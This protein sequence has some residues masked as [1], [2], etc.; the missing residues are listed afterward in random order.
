MIHY[1]NQWQHLPVNVSTWQCHSRSAFEHPVYA[2]AKDII[3]KQC[4][5]ILDVGCGIAHDA[6]LFPRL[7]YVGLDVTPKFIHE[8]HRRGYS[9]LV[10]SCLSL[11]F[12]DHAFDAVLTNSLLVHLPPAMWRPSLREMVR[13]ASKLV[14]TIEG[15]WK[16]K[17]QYR[18]AEQYPF[19]GGTLMFYN[20]AYGEAEVRAFMCDYPIQV[21]S[22]GH[23]Q[24]TIYNVTEE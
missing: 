1:F 3:Q 15:A 18:H 17:T 8:A 22:D 24:A 7:R 14:V 11:P 10:G 6:A 20:N 9:V 12:P 21:F 16:I 23:T 5:S 19:E 4:A 13:V 2:A